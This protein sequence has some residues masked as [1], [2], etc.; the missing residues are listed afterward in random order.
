MYETREKKNNTPFLNGQF[1]YRKII[2]I[3]ESPVDLTFCVYNNNDDY[4]MCVAEQRQQQ[5]GV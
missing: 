5:R 3:N 1:L 4:R 2:I